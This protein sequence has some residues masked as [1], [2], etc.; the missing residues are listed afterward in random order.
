MDTDELAR[1]GC[2]SADRRSD[3][4]VP[5]SP[6]ST[7]GPVTRVSVVNYMCPLGSAGIAKVVVINGVVAEILY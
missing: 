6:E 3:Y 5:M 7:R 2:V 1:C 4:K